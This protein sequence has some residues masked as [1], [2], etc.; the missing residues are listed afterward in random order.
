MVVAQSVED[1]LELFSGGGDSADV[2]VAAAMGHPFADGTDAAGVRQDF[3][4]SIAA[5]RTRREP[6]LVIRPRC[7]VVSDSW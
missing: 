4:D 3:T 5:R 1:E 2:A 6:C 7:T